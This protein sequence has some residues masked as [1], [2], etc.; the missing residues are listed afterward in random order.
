MAYVTDFVTNTR[1]GPPHAH[2][3]PPARGPRLHSHPPAR[4]I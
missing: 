2:P 4:G 3:R 1:P